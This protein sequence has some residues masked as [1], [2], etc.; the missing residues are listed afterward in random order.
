MNI[1]FILVVSIFLNV[2]PVLVERAFYVMGTIL[3]FKLYCGDRGSCNQAISNAYLEVKKL[4]DMLS[5]YKADSKLSEV[6]SLA[7][8][9]KIRVPNEFLELTER[10][11]LF[12]NL[13]GGAFDITVG[14]LI[15]L[16]RQ[17]QHKN[18]VPDSET[19]KRTVT[20]CVGFKKIELYSKEKEIDIKSPCLSID[21]GGIGKG[22]A[23]DRAV[24]ILKDKGVK[25]GILNFGGEIYTIGA[26]PGK[27]GWLVG[28]QNPI[29]QENMLAFIEVKDMAVSTSGD[30]ERFFE[31]QG[32]RYSHIVDPRTGMP[33]ETSPSVTVLSKSATD[34][35][36]LSTAISVM[37]KEKSPDVLKKYENVGLVIVTKEKNG[38]SIH[39]NAFFRRFEVRNSSPD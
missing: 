21:F 24:G 13:T 25:S 17:G 20:N 27:R 36:A 35:E 16:W 31:I 22:Y 6:N 5:N 19:V 11:L 4:D 3:E 18:T 37:G 38:L 7:G 12:S 9:G 30:Y 14:K 34:A 33:V 29:K 23:I 28:V 10:S 32:K 1:A 8:T 26:P 2:K 15:E 39:K